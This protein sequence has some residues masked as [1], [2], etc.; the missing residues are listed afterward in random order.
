MIGLIARSEFSNALR[1]PAAWLLFAAM[2]LVCAWQF[3]AQ[4][5]IFLQNQARLKTIA[6]APGATDLVVAP[7]LANAALVLLLIVPLLT[8][9]AIAEERSLRSF[10]LLRAAPIGNLQIVLGKFLGCALIA[11]VPVALVALMPVA[12]LAG[13][14]I[15]P[16]QYLAGVL[17]L[18]LTALLFIAAGLFVS[19]LTRNPALAAGGAMLLL[20][21]IWL[22]DWGG[23]GGG[24]DNLL[25]HLSV[26]RHF[27]P[28]LRGVLDSADL[29]YF[30][31]AIG[32]FLA[33]AV[34]RLATARGL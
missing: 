32:L 2:Q 31:V 13:G 25:A 5:E 15:D 8:M 16:G 4:L 1:N 34:W 33:L 7:T 20:L 26:A 14:A 12:L 22:L 21:M 6:G 10:V 24:E 19:T 3:L 23:A 27:E 29:A 28:L 18:L 17:G 30:A 9:R 11:A